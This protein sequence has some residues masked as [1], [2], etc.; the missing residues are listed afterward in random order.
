MKGISIIIIICFSLSTLSFSQTREAEIDSVLSDWDSSNAPGGSVAIVQNGKLIFSKGYGLADLEH[1]IFIN[2]SSIFYIGSTGKQFT[3]FSIFL[4]EEQGKLALNDDIGKYLTGFPDYGYSITIADLLYHTS[5]IKDYSSLWDLQGRS[6]FDLIT[7]EETYQLLINQSSLNFPPGTESLYSNGGYFLLSE[8]IEKVADQ[9]LKEF[10]QENIFDPLGMTN[11]TFLDNHK[12]LIPN[13]APGYYKNAQKG[14]FDN[15]IRRFELVGSGGVYSN[16]LD[17]YRWDQNFFSNKLG[18]GNQ[19][20]INKMYKLGL[21]DNR[22]SSGYAAGLIIGKYKGLRRISHGGSHGGYKAQ[23]LRFPDQG[24]SVILLSN[25]S[26]TRIDTKAYAI[27]DL[28][29]NKY[30]QIEEELITGSSELKEINPKTQRKFLGHYLNE[31]TGLVRKI[32][33]RNESLYYSRSETSQ[34]KIFPI[35][36][37]EFAVGKIDSKNT[38]KFSNLGSKSQTMTFLDSGKPL[39]TFQLFQ[40]VSYNIEE[41]EKYKGIYYSQDL[42]TFYELKNKDGQ[43]YLFINRNMLDLLKPVTKHIFSSTKFGV[44]NF[45]LDSNSKIIGIKVNSSRVR[46]LNFDKTN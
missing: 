3:A 38:I 45:Q 16:V 27:A 12:D 36:K 31:E 17:L 37:A 34:D 2:P 30:F 39:N 6:Y 33:Q 43:L 25:R 23:L 21:L 13:R 42:D 19:E 29:L 22:E 4:L 40:P 44:F 9:S 1:H 10:A 15:A 35:G 7:A 14:G 20:I 41:L 32:I 18:K 28:Y 5:G 24:F 26:D 11:T 46:N 8:I